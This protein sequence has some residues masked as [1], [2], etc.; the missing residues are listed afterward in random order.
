MSA[1]EVSELRKAYGSV[2][3]VDGISF[4]VRTGEI[5]SMLG[6]NGAGK[7]TTIEILEGLRKKDSGNVNV[8]G[9]D[10]WAKG[11]ELHRKIGVIPQGFR[12]FDK[13]TPREAIKY[14]GD[15]FEVKIDPN[16]IL[17]EVILEDSANI[18]FQ[19]LS[20]G[21]KQKVGLALALVNDPELL[22]LD[23]PTT[24]LDPQA[25]RAVWQVIRNLKKAG[26]S[27]MLTTHYLEEA[28]QLADRVAIMNKGRIIAAGSPPELIAQYSTGERLRVQAGKDLYDYISS[29]TSLRV[30]YNDKQGTVEIFLRNKG[31]ALNAFNAIE[32]SGV[33]WN[34]LSTE[35]DSLE[36][37]FIKL[38]GVSLDEEGETQQPQLSA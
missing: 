30:Q 27:V 7:T 31:D 22:F 25:R 35:K 37:I 24:G 1:I 4:N 16:V 5:F 28:Q 14:Y 18:V 19:D 10:P 34:D 32:Q 38:V 20:V 15:L 12:F 23:E 36:D 21:Q 29:R 9:F 2:I 33:P 26:R 8:L 3:A 13:C 6:P 11:Y 17:R